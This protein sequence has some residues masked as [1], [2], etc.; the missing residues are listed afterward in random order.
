VTAPV[1]TVPR[2]AP[3]TFEHRRSALDEL[4]IEWDYPVL[5]GDSGGVTVAPKAR[6]ALPYDEAMRRVAGD[7]PRPLLLLREC[8]LCQGT[9][10][11][12]LEVE[13]TPEKTLLFARWF[14]CV[15]FDDSVRHESH[16][17]HALFKD[18]AMPH[19]ILCERDGGTLTR[20]DGKRPQSVL[21]RSMRTVLRRA[22]VKDPDVAVREV[23]KVL[24]QFDHLDS[25]EAEVSA[26]LQVA[27]ERESKDAARPRELEAERAK[28]AR[29]REELKKALEETLDLGLKT[30]AEVAKTAPAEEASTGR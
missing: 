8:W 6:V 18:N 21:W 15:R 23:F 5:V 24:A 3:I 11:A 26:Q 25:M 2:G 4:R 13:E 29:Q 1:T 7:D 20:L 17:F 30:A 28:I 19:L 22:Y 9:E 10:S 16:P 14:H 12:L 27:L